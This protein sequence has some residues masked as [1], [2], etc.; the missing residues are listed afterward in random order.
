MKGICFSGG[1]IK[2]V[3]H[4][5]AL[6]ALENNNIKFDAVSGTSSGSIIS[7]LYALGYSSDEML[8]LFIKYSKN[9]KQVE[10]GKILK[11]I[12]GLI[13]QGKIIINGLNSGNFIERAIEDICKEKNIYNINEIEMPI[14]IPTVDIQTGAVIVATSKEVRAG[15]SDETKYI[16]DIPIKIAVRSSC[17]YPV[18]IAPCVY[19]ETEFVDGG[20]RE[21]IP[22]KELKDFGVDNIL[23]IGFETINRTESYDNMIEIATRSIDLICHELLNYEIEGLYKLVKIPVPKVS[24]LDTSKI[25]ELYQIG[26]ETMEKKI[27]KIF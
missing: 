19:K 13:T 8:E 10:I 1:G 16:N 4:I 26:Y 6:K 25:E 22:W 18:V 24:L 20:I 9:I 14:F 23:A 21:N 17:S 12:W 3:A 2:A 27:N 11:L 7:V 5:G 15:I